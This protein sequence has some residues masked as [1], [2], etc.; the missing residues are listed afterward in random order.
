MQFIPSTEIKVSVLP[1]QRPWVCS[2]DMIRPDG[3]AGGHHCL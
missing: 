1:E 2:P 3:A